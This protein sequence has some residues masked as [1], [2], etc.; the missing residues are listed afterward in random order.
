VKNRLTRITTRTGDQ[1]TSGLA[2]GSRHDKYETVFEVM[3]DIDELNSMLGVVVAKLGSGPTRE[4]LSAIQSR[5]FDL[6]AV[7]AVPGSEA[8]MGLEITDLDALISTYNAPL[9][10]LQN[11]VLPGGDAVAADLHLARAICRRA[12]R[13]CWRH[14]APHGRDT[15]VSGAVYLNRLADFLFVLA[16]SVNVTAN[17]TEVLWEPRQRSE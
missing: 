11:F 17:A 7:L 2:D 16:R 10:P 6:G 14:L 13:A 1:G 5:L 8:K 15:D 4:Q 9:P 3:G 12:E